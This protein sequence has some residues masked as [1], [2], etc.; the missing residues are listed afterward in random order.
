M[1]KATIAKRCERCERF[2]DLPNIMQSLAREIIIEYTPC[3]H[4]LYSKDVAHPRS[5]RSGRCLDCSIPFAIVDH[6]AKGR[7]ERCSRSF[8]RKNEKERCQ[9]CSTSF[10]VVPHRGR[11]RCVNCGNIKERDRNKGVC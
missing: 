3:P 10:E 2:F 9:V 5:S 1:R 7:C 11:G 8:L 4:C 6:H